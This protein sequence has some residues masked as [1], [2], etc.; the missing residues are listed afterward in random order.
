MKRFLFIFVAI[1][2]LPF[3]AAAKDIN[4]SRVSSKDA[5]E[6]G[7]LEPQAA[8]NA[9]SGRTYSFSRMRGGGGKRGKDAFPF[10]G[11]VVGYF[12]PNGTVHVWAKKEEKVHSGKWFT[13]KSTDKKAGTLL[14][15]DFANNNEK[16]LC[17]VI[18][19]F[20]KNIYYSAKGNVFN[21]R[22]GRAV[23]KVVKSHK[24]DLQ[25]TA[26]RLGM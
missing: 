19:V 2:L 22:G 24:R 21:L 14:C 4:A 9:I 7:F 25:D 26:D 12:A 17:A 20:G 6:I 15:F 23:P 11:T 13:G 8:F 5:R 10:S 3:S 18:K 1:V 16:N